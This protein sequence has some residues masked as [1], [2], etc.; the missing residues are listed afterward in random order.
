MKFTKIAFGIV[1]AAACTLPAMAGPH[2][3]D[4]R[5]HHDNDGVRL[6]A[7]IIG[8]VGAVLQP[9]PKVVVAPP[10]VVHCPPPAPVV[11]C[12]PP[13]PRHHHHRPAPPPRHHGPRHHGRR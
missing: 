2:H 4:H 11:H 8:L 10:P 6:A 3:R 1:L 9:A 13:P 7:N 12:P 5:R